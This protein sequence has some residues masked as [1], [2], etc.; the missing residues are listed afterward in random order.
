MSS[1]TPAPEASGDM[2]HSCSGSFGIC[3]EMRTVPYAS[4]AWPDRLVPVSCGYTC[5]AV[6]GY[7]AVHV[8]Q[9]LPYYSSEEAPDTEDAVGDEGGEGERDQREIKGE[10]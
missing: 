4:L 8:T 6:P 7:L 2:C 3:Q 5:V 10:G 9:L 1:T